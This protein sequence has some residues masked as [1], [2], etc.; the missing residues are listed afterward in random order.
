MQRKFTFTAADWDLI[1]DDVGD[2]N[3]YNYLKDAIEDVE[4]WED[5][6]TLT[7]NEEEAVAVQA[8]AEDL[9]LDECDSA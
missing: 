2:D 8:T 6:V 4:D 5:P 3:L 1:A 9:G 7:L